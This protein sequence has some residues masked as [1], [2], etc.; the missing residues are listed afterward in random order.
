MR[1]QPRTVRPW[2]RRKAFKVVLGSVGG[3]MV[4]RP[5]TAAT[6]LMPTPPQSTGPFYPQIKPLEVDAD[7]L[8]IAEQDE[9]AAGTP[10]HL[11]GRVL[12]PAGQPL[13]GALVE[14]WQC[15]SYGVYHHPLDRGRGG[16]RFDPRFQ[17]Y[18]R[19]DTAA[20]GG[21]RFR[22]IRPVA[23]PGRTP[24]IHVRVT[25]PGF[26]PLTTQMYVAG[27]PLNDTDVLLSRVRDPAARKRIIIALE[28]LPDAG[29]AD[30][31]G[32]FNIVFGA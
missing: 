30:L 29:P 11:L 7:L 31:V 2:S 6:A 4:A 1:Q 15:D 18:G 16:R 19:S 22:T 5:S 9:L 21:Y 10:L 27:E 23:Y 24:H 13:E 32:V 3:V 28:P 26:E 20:D 25:A 8:R 12:D 17:G 14:I